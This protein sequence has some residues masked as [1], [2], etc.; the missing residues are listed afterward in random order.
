MMRLQTIVE[1]QPEY[2]GMARTTED[3]TDVV[4]MVNDSASSVH[5]R[6]IY[7]E[8]G[9]VVEL[10]YGRAIVQ[11]RVGDWVVRPRDCADD[12]E[13]LIISKAAMS[14]YRVLPTASTSNDTA[15]TSDA[16]F[17]L[18]NLDARYGEARHVERLLDGLKRLRGGQPLAF[19]R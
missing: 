10:H 6:L 9:W 2:L 12:D 13:W 17:I 15:S 19:E 7:D 18:D 5:A 11:V 1:S 3:D 8:R 16:P 14:R 4:R